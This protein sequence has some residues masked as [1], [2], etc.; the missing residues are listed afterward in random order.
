MATNTRPGMPTGQT[1]NEEFFFN[2]YTN[3]AK[4]WHNKNEHI[5]SKAL[6]MEITTW[7]TKVGNRE[8]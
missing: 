6:V 4:N 5:Y 8:I 3:R 7:G 2:T 1:E